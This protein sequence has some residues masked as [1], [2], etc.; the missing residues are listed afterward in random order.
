MCKRFSIVM[1]RVRTIINSRITTT[2]ASNSLK[3]IINREGGN[4]TGF[5][6]QNTFLIY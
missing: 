2:N 1:L 3:D 4:G 6:N 5:K